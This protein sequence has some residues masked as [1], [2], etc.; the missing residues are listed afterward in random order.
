MTRENTGRTVKHLQSDGKTVYSMS[1]NMN[2][3]SLAGNRKLQMEPEKRIDVTYRDS[4]GKDESA[5]IVLDHVTIKNDK[6]RNT[7]LDLSRYRS[8]LVKYN[9]SGD[10][11]KKWSKQD[12]EKDYNQFVSNSMQRMN[13]DDYYYFSGRGDGDKMFWVKYHPQM[14]KTGWKKGLDNIIK[15]GSKLDKNFKQD[16]Q[17]AQVDFLAKYANRANKKEMLEMFEKQYI[18]NVMYDLSMNGMNVNTANIKKILG[19]GFIN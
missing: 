12:G 5:Y 15:E 3:T 7:D 10:A 16:Y 4:G 19:S 2:P 8:H 18:S 1:D 9:L 6:G 14:P 11:R 17:R 13:K